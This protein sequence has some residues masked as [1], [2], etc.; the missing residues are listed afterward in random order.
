MADNS[1]NQPPTLLSLLTGGLGTLTRGIGGFDT[2]SAQ[3]S[4]LYY[5]AAIAANNAT[6]A[7][8]RASI[9][10]DNGQVQAQDQGLKTAQTFGMQRANLAANGVDLGSGGANDIL[11]STRLMGDRDM[12]QIQTNAM[13]EA[14]GYQTQATDFNSNA[15]AL[16]NMAGS[17][18]PA[19]ST[20]TSLQDGLNALAPAVNQ[21]LLA[22]KGAP[23]APVPTPSAAAPSGTPSLL[24][25]ATLVNPALLRS[26][27]STGSTQ[28]NWA[29]N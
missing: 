6:L 22:Q 17:V 7:Q 1:D 12:A 21:Y 19:L 27:T 16:K 5:Q 26:L 23:Q 18:S 2:A 11:T 8:G 9:A 24:G 28:Q 15:T 29:Y 14:W 4:S 25:G 20:A 13:R 10:Q 3:R